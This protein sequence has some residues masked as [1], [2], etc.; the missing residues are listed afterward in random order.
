MRL[1][2]CKLF[3][4]LASG[5]C[6]HCKKLSYFMCLSLFFDMF[7]GVVPGSLIQHVICSMD[8]NKQSSRV[9]FGMWLEEAESF[10]MR[11]CREHN[12][13]CC[14][15]CYFVMQAVSV[16]KSDGNP[17]RQCVAVGV[18]NIHHAH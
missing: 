5:F 14:A 4:Y 1:P 12:L 15:S 13:V 9:S 2:K 11:N 16:L 7:N 17:S 6:W 18:R 10:C 3:T 8:K